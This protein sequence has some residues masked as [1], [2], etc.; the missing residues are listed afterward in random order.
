ME[1]N[2]LELAGILVPAALTLFVFSYLVGDNG[3][4]RLAEHM[5][6]GV[7]VG[8]ALVVAFH[9]I[10]GPKLLVPLADVLRSG[11]TQ[12][13]PV[14]LVPLV[15]GLLLLLRPTKS[16]SWFGSLSVAV[17]LGVGAALAIA[18]AL[19]GTL[20]PQVTATADIRQYIPGY[21]PALGLASGIIALIGTIAVLLY[22]HRSSGGQSRLSGLS[23]KVV[24][25]FGGAGRWL[26]VIAFGAILASTFLSRLSLLSGRL[27]FLID[28]VRRLLGGLG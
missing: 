10:L 11:N 20:I 23:D 6:V 3:L 15:L 14:L 12:Q 8:Y 4:Y 18:G 2:L 27:E 9:T 19:I 5:F 13:L 7:A 17:L 26:I 24:Q 21:G 1:A 28:A 22:F 25:T 16:L